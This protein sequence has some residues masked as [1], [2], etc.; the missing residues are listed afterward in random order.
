MKDSE[1]QAA[2]AM[3][4]GMSPELLTAIATLTGVALGIAGTLSAARIQ[5]KGSHAQADATFRAAQTT[6]LT[7]YAATLDQQNRAA[8]RAAYVGYLAA[9]GDFMRRAEY[10]RTS[11]GDRDRSAQD[12]SESY[13]RVETA[14]AAVELEGPDAVLAR[15]RDFRT[16]SFNFE[17]VLAV[18]G[19]AYRAMNKLW[20]VHYND[21]LQ[22]F[23]AIQSLDRLRSICGEMSV[24]DRM[25]L[26]ISTDL[27][28]VAGDFGEIGTRW[29]TEFGQAR[30]LLLPYAEAG[31][32][33]QEEVEVI[34][35][36]AGTRERSVGDLLDSA[37]AE[38]DAALGGFVEDARTHLSGTAPRHDL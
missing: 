14:L 12:L 18:F 35:R 36:D 1:A 26:R 2:Q 20:A 5:A 38:M 31:V 27:F 37:Q 33:T 23:P 29:C 28:S 30:S 25:R 24:H 10:T 32:I 21:D 22:D 34:L 17:H 8:Q 6:A 9:A 11:E 7:Q 13:Q 15:A 16:R 19:N 3:M 4:P